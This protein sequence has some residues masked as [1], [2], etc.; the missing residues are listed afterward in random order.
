MPCAITAAQIV[1]FFPYASPSDGLEDGLGKD[2]RMAGACYFL[3]VC[4]FVCFYSSFPLPLP[5]FLCLHTTPRNPDPLIHAHTF[6]FDSNTPSYIQH[7]AFIP[8]FLYSPFLSWATKTAPPEATSTSN[9]EEQRST[10][11][12]SPHFAHR[13]EDQRRPWC[14]MH[15]SRRP[16]LRIALGITRSS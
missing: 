1:A 9:L 11:R 10:P 7:H 2:C 16:A 3:S 14:C 12:P 15:P 4:S 5:L 6:T 13:K 8:C